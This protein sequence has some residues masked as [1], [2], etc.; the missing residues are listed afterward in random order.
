MVSGLD[1]LILSFEILDF[2]RYIINLIW[3]DCKFLEGLFITLYT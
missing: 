3:P 2:L 1:T